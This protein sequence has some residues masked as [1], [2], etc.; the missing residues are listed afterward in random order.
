[1]RIIRS[2]N[3]ISGNNIVGHYQRSLYDTYQSFLYNGSSWT[4]YF[5]TIAVGS[6]AVDKQNNKW[7]GTDPVWF[8]QCNTSLQSCRMLH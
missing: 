5:D 7:F 3:G 4:T 8:F 6:I 2:V 1:M